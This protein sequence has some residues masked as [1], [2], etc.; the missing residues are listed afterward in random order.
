MLEKKSVPQFSDYRR[1]NSETIR[2]GDL[3]IQFDNLKKALDRTNLYNASDELNI[4]EAYN[5]L[6]FIDNKFVI[7]DGK[8]GPLSW[9]KVY[10]ATDPNWFQ[11]KAAEYWDKKPAEEAAGIGSAIAKELKELTSTEEMKEKYGASTDRKIVQAMKR[12]IYLRREMDAQAKE[13]VKQL[14]PK[15]IKKKSHEDKCEDLYWG[16]K[17]KDSSGKTIQC[18]AP[19]GLLM[20][21]LNGEQD[22]PTF[23]TGEKRK[24]CVVDETGGQVCT[25]ADKSK[26]YHLTI[27]KINKRLKNP[28]YRAK[29]ARE[30]GAETTDR[31]LIFAYI[32]LKNSENIEAMH[33]PGHGMLYKQYR[34]TPSPGAKNDFEVTIELDGVHTNAEWFRGGRNPERQLNAYVEEKKSG[35]RAKYAAFRLAMISHG[36]HPDNNF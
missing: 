30:L 16:T 32:A 34:F 29:M 5:I 10:F 15:E 23:I 12:F 13:E 21:N 27:D 3:D 26:A 31:D 17:Y 24:R 7:A 4:V 2:S 25:P 8:V 1:T 36:G 20:Y 6:K 11:K 33:V 28:A 18:R 9:S 14:S 22:H 35:P 19:D